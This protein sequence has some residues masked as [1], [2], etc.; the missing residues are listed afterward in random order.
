[1]FACLLRGVSLPMESLDGDEL[2]SRSVI[3]KAPSAALETIR[4]DLVHPP[5]FYF[6]LKATTL[7]AGSDAVG[8]R[9][10]SLI[11]GVITILSLWLWGW[12]EPKLRWSVAAA[13]VLIVLNPTHVYYSQ[14]ARSYSLYSLLVCLLAAWAFR[15]DHDGHRKTFWAIGAGIM[16]SVVYTHYYGWLYIMSVVIPIGLFEHKHRC[17]VAVCVTIA[18]LLFVPWIFAVLPVYAAKHGLAYNLG[19]QGQP[20][21]YEL[22]QVWADSVGVPDIRRGM[23]VSMLTIIL[24]SMLALAYSWREDCPR[25]RRVTLTVAMLAVL[26]PSFTFLISQE[27]LA[28]PIFGQRHLLPSLFATVAL[29]CCGL[30]RL[31]WHTATPYKV[32]VCGTAFLFLLQGSALWK[33]WPGP[34]RQPYADIAKDLGNR[35]GAAVYTTHQYLIGEPVSFYLDGKRRVYPLPAKLPAESV[36]LYRPVIRREAGAVHRTTQPCE[37]SRLKYYSAEAS[38]FGTQMLL[39]KCPGEYI[40]S[41][42]PR[43]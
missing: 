24:L 6:A 26:P 34:R 13:S 8:V 7:L 43:S 1:M 27:P 35:K 28:L 10:L 4:Q 15:I 40:G 42:I 3:L 12:A 17:R 5:L 41:A 33:V 20:T 2:F 23:S 36:V 25:G 11:C 14:Q 19:W 29:V 32:L 39:V 31:A 30:W 21:Y 37:V 9:I 18:I 16:I 38:A 22:I